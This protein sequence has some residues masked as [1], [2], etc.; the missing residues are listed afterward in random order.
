MVTRRSTSQLTPKASYECPSPNY[1]L[2]QDGAE[3]DVT[4]GMPHS[5]W[6]IDVDGPTY[7]VWYEGE[8]VTAADEQAVISSLK[9]LD[10]LPTP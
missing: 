8:G 9:F 4:P 10:K 2:F 5:L 6:I 7:I 1:A 3:R